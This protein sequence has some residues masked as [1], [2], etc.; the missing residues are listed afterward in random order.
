MLQRGFES[1]LCSKAHHVSDPHQ[2]A[3]SVAFLHLAVDQVWLNLPLAHVTPSTTQLK[4]LTKVGRES[5][6]V[7]IEPITRKERETARGPAF[8]QSVDERCAMCCVRGP[9]S[10]TENFVQGINGQPEPQH[11]FGIA[12]PGAQFIQLEMRDLEVWKQRSCKVCA[13]SS[14]RV[15]HVV[16]VACR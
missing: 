5:I 9:S 4:P 11:L 16:M 7:E 3:P 14:A 13:C 1:G 8:S 12:Q 15:S 2:L 10:S 6:K